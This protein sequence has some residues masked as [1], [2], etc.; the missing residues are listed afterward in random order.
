[1]RIELRHIC[2]DRAKY[3]ADM[4]NF[5]SFDA[6]SFKL[7]R[8]LID[9]VKLVLRHFRVNRAII[10]ALGYNLKTTCAIVTKLGKWMNGSLP[11]RYAP[12]LC[13]LRRNSRTCL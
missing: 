6:I 13:Q 11:K 5:R 8:M 4:N 3:E 7:C 9:N 1:M 12:V 2:P 10:A